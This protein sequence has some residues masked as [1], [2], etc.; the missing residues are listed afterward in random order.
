MKIIDIVESSMT[1]YG[2]KG[3]VGIINKNRIIKAAEFRSKNK[4]DPQSY[5]KLVSWDGDKSFKETNMIL[6][7]EETKA[8]YGAMREL[9]KNQQ[10]LTH[11]YNE[12]SDAM[13]IKRLAKMFLA[14]KQG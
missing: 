8:F 12:I 4:D 7:P 5:T 2:P 9:F 6:S 13:Q 1:A 3:R 10:N 14:T 11:F